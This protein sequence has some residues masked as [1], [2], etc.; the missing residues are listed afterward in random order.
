MRICH[1]VDCWKGEVK[2]HGE[3]GAKVVSWESIVI[4][5]V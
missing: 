2:G 3:T 5:P 1:L 4:P